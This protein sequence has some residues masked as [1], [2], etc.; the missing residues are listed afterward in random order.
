M[1]KSLG[2]AINWFEIPVADL[3]RATKFYET[4]FAKPLRLETMGPSQMAVFAY[5]REGVGG[6]LMKSGQM[7]PHRDGAVVYL[8]AA[9]SIDTVLERIAKAGGAVSLAKTALPE[10]M[11]FFAHMIDT[12]GNRVGLHALS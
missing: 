3:P 12:E 1:K 5:D 4:I 10:G 7:K 9:P 8:N 2:N 11:G 6:C